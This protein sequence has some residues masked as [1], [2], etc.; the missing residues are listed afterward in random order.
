MFSVDEHYQGDQEDDTP[1]VPEDELE[2]A[3][4]AAEADIAA[5]TNS[6]DFETNPPKKTTLLFG[7]H[8]RKEE[9]EA[10]PTYDDLL[11]EARSCKAELPGAVRDKARIVRVRELGFDTFSVSI[12]NEGGND[13]KHHHHGVFCTRSIV[14]ELKSELKRCGKL[15]PVQVFVDCE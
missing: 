3:G 5:E 10:N 15:S 11:R 1:E 8:H 2:I 12:G 6:A 4:A 13:E 14:S 7:Y 9:K